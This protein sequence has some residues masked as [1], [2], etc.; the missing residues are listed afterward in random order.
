MSLVDQSSGGYLYV[1]GVQEMASWVECLSVRVSVLLLFSSG[2]FP[3]SRLEIGM[4]AA[5]VVA[6]VVTPRAGRI[7]VCFE[8]AGA[9]QK[10][11]NGALAAQLGASAAVMAP[12]R[13]DRSAVWFVPACLGLPFGAVAACQA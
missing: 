12:S 7:A 9:F 8:S 2:L 5:R 10:G 4:F 11:R 13:L 3:F 6:A 1:V